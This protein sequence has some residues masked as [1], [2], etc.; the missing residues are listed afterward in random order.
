M[1]HPDPDW[2]EREYDPSQYKTA[3]QVAFVV[4][5]LLVGVLIGA[6]LFAGDDPVIE[7]TGY[8]TNLF[9]EVISVIVTVGLFGLVTRHLQIEERKRTLVRNA[10][11]DVNDIAKDAINDLRHYGWLTGEKGLLK[12]VVLF[13]ANLQGARLGRANLQ[14]TDLVDAN[15][16]GAS[17]LQANLQSANLWG[18]NLQGAGLGD[19]NLA[20]ANLGGANLAGASLV[21]AN[22]E[23]ANLT[24]VN[25]RGADLQRANLQDADLRGAEFD[26]NTMLPDAVWAND[27]DGWTSYWSPATDMA[28]FTDPHH[29]DFW[30]PDWV[31]EQQS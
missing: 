16:Q 23:G 29:P 11:K 6:S 8:W 13:Q 2:R 22:L 9:T 18:V 14:G 17:L 24:G 21:H 26:L 15:L 27:A 3:A 1:P 20:G 19:A 10:G 30:Q 25:L 31:K 4:I 5:V 7:D 12:G 28:R